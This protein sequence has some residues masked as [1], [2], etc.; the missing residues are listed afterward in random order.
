MVAIILDGGNKC[1]P[2]EYS[3]QGTNR[4]GMKISMDREVPSNNV[5]KIQVSFDFLQF[6]RMYFVVKC[7]SKNVCPPELLLKDL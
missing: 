2:H 7:P 4:L 5:N 3:E 6:Y 1:N